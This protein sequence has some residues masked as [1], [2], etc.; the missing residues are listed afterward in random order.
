MEK[1]LHSLKENGAAWPFLTPVDPEEV[2][3][4]QDVIKNPMGNPFALARDFVDAHLLH[5]YPTDL[6]TMTRKLE[7]NQYKNIEQFVDDALL[8]FDNCR[9]YNPETTIWARNAVKMEKYLKELLP[10]YVRRD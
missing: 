6:S 4:Y 9:A 7:A 8:I 3:D 10:S 1:T 5:L 2:P